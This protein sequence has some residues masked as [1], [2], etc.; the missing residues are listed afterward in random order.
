MVVNMFVNG[1]KWSLMMLVHGCQWMLDANNL[2]NLVNEV[3]SLKFLVVTSQHRPWQGHGMAT[4]CWAS[5]GVR[6]RIHLRRNV[7]YLWRQPDGALP[8]PGGSTV[9]AAARD[10]LGD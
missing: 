2:I 9:S 8:S 7:R 4:G 3:I 5:P 6:G 1:C 10:T